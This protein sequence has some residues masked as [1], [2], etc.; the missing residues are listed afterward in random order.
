MHFRAGLGLAAA[1][2]ATAAAPGLPIAVARQP[3]I[4]APAPSR[5]RRPVKRNKRRDTNRAYAAQRVLAKGNKLGRR[6][7]RKVALGRNGAF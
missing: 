2:L 7:R 5:A 6:L 1:L 4:A 3:A